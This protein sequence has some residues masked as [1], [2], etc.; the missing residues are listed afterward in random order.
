MPTYEYECGG[1]DHRFEEFQG[2]TDDKLVTCPAC[3]E[4]TLQ[5][6]IGA[7]AAVLFK[8]SGFY[9]TDYRSD[10]YNAKAKADTSDSSSTSPAN[11][12][13]SESTSESSS[14]STPAKSEPAKSEP[15]SP[16]SSSSSS[17]SSSTKSAE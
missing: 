15:A 1:C 9:Q 17:E 8:G 4:D 3:G 6:L 10:D 12:A 14:E 2:I 7:G 13:A 11:N 5:R 16:S